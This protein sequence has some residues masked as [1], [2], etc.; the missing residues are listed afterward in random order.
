ML[1]HRRK[2]HKFKR[3]QEINIDKLLKLEYDNRVKLFHYLVDHNPSSKEYKAVFVDGTAD[4]IT[5]L[6]DRN[7]KV[8]SYFKSKHENIDSFP[9]SSGDWMTLQWEPNE[10]LTADAE[11]TKYS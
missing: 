11:H 2:L 5:I 8:I 3:Y 7:E 9:A 1:E 4:W 10:F 6:S